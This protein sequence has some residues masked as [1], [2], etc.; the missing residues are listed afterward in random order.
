VRRRSFIAGAL[1]AVG[2]G[3]SEAAD[4]RH[5]GRFAI[6]P[7]RVFDGERVLGGH[8]AVIEGPTVA[9]VVPA[10]RVSSGVP[11]VHAPGCTLL[12]GLIDMHVHF[13]RWQGPQYLAWGVTTVRDVGNALGWIL[14]RRVE[15]PR[16]ACPRILCAG[17]LLDGP[18]PFHPL[19]ARGCRDLPDS[20]A[21]VRETAAAG[22]DAIKLY[23]GIPP[24]WV[25]DMARE[26]H[27]A[28]LKVSMHCAGAGV[29]AAAHGGVDE[30]HHLDGV[31]D[32]IWPG[33]PPGWLEAWGAPE[34][35]S[36][37]AGCQRE[38]ADDIAACGMASTPTLTYWRSQWLVRSPRY[39]REREQ[40]LVPPELVRLQLPAGPDPA[41][42]VQWFRALEAAQ[43]FVRL[44]L[45]RGVTIL[46]GTDTPC[47]AVAPGLSLWQE[48]VLLSQGGMSAPQALRT[49]TSGAADF[50]GRP[51]LGRLRPGCTADAVLVRGDP[52]R[53]VPAEPDIAAVYR[54]GERFEPA[55]LLADAEAGRFD[56]EGDPWTEQFRAHSR[57]G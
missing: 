39:V 5:V 9:D 3:V 33:H 44:L 20:L 10:H 53:A 32:A 15:W 8:A 51:E 7:D 11:V 14:A 25:A 48:L 23:V 6:V 54:E 21:A 17:P 34:L 28:S 49:A 46:A 31:L 52:T 47:G 22:V 1:A 41:G 30:F 36:A 16:H 2:L 57:T 43:G 29:L 35:A 42:A 4:A 24:E 18:A 37:T 38:V 19:V 27:T 12:P 26:S 40:R 56:L 13:M 50:L 45:E 55:R